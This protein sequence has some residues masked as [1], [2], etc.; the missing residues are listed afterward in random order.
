MTDSPKPPEPTSYGPVADRILSGSAPLP[1]RTAAA[2]GALPLP[3]PVLV[4]LYLT[5]RQDPEGDVRT[6][7]EASLGLLS[8][9]ALKDVVGDP[10]CPPDVLTHFAVAAARDEALA[11][12]IVFHPLVPDEA[13]AA[14]ASQGNAAVIE[15]VLTNQVR[16]LSSPGLLDRLTVNPALRIDQR[17]RI[18]DLLDRFFQQA[19]AESGVSEEGASSEGLPADLKE[20]ARLLEVDVGEI[21]ASSEIL[22][23]HEFEQA[24]D[25][26]VR[27][28][29]QTILTLNTAQKAM[30]A[31][32][33]G[34]EE[35]MILIRDTNKV[36]ALSV[37]KN[38]RITELE[39]E[40]IS[41]MR[42]VSE[43]ILRAV[44]NHRE[45]QKSYS[46]ILNLVNNP[47]TPP[48]VSTNFVGRLV[49]KDVKRL[50]GDKNVPEVIRRMAKRTH[51]LRT[52]QAT[53]AF[54]KK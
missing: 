54:R 26:V 49:T 23:G 29:Y 27:T 41:R 13:L 7:A 38:G 10:A 28:A 22:D 19:A 32:K 45:W 11:E 35:R 33:G 3:R 53:P 14:L 46:V 17:G 4:L 25:P 2:R 43:E 51:D 37:L 30:L 40:A 47:R 36:V 42:N 18:L 1:L 39:V 8:G 31:M 21:F 15:L 12:R 34:R 16:L 9:E 52:Q 44:G 5:L 50:A 48:G 24:E 20:A 6:H